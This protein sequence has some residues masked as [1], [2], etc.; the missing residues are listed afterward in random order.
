MDRSALEEA[1]REERDPKVKDRVLMIMKLMDGFSSHEVGRQH[2]R[3]HSRVLEWKRRFEEEGL[4]GLRGRPRSGRPPE[5]PRWRM[6]RIRKVVEERDYWKATEVKE[7]IRDRAGHEYSI[8]H[9]TR[10]LHKW[11]F[12]PKKPGRRHVKAASD[13]TVRRFKKRPERPS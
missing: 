1:W 8:M 10:I 11:G 9:V 7:L 4:E 3:S 5:V 13:R 2:H 12:S 6:E